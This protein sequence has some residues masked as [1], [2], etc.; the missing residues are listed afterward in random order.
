MT[1]PGKS[2]LWT[3]LFFV[4]SLSGFAQKTGILK[5]VVKDAETGETLPNVGISVVGT[6]LTAVTDFNGQYQ[7]PNVP[8]GDYSIKIQVL[9][10]GTQLINGLRIPGGKILVRNIQL[11]A[12]VDVLQTVTVL[13]QRAQVDL[14]SAKSERSIT[15][16]DIAQM[17]VR[18]VEEVVSLQAGVAKTNDG[19]QIRGARVYETEYLVDGISAQDPL[20]GTG[21]GVRVQS[22][23]IQSVKVTT[24]GAS[25]EF[26]GGSSGV[27]ST[28]IREGGDRL[29]V[30][31]RIT[32]DYLNP[33]NTR[34][35]T[36]FNTDQAELNISFPIPGTK[37]KVTLFNSA[38]A[39]IT[40]DYFPNVATQ[41]QSSL[42]PE[43]PTQWAPRQSNSW[44][45]TAKLGWQ[46]R[47][48]TK[49]TIT[50]QHSLNINQNSRTL[51]I[52]GFDAILAP[53]Y[54]YAR[55]KNLDNAATY[56]HHSNL[57]ALNL[58]HIINPKV[59]LTLS[60][61]RM[62][63]NLRADAN[64]RPFRSATVD[65]ILDE[66]NIASYPLD[67]FNPY[68][69][70]GIFYI[71]P[72][73]GLVNNGGITSTWHDH[74][75]QEYTLRGKINY[76]PGTV[77]Q[78]VTGWEHQWNEYQWVDVTT[79]WVGA[80]IQINDSL[81]TPSISIGSSNDIWKVNPQKGGLF[82]EDQINYKG[83]QASLGLRFN[84]WAPGTFADRAIADSTAPVIPAIRSDYMDKTLALGG[85]RWKAR[86]LPRINVSFP[87][88]PNNVLYF[89]YGHSM[90]LPHPRFLYAGLDPVYQDRS[91]LSFLGNP[92]LDPEVNV[93]YEVGYKAALNRDLGITVGAYNNNRF[94]YIVSRRVIVKDQTGRPV[95]KT[96]YINQDYAKIQGLELG[97]DYRFAR[98]FRLFGNGSFQVA[99]GK[100]NS[101]R[102]SA[103]QIEQNGEVS[104]TRENFLA[105]DRPW[106]T[107]WGLFFSADSTFRI[108]RLSLAGL[109]GYLQY[110]AS[111]GYRYT[112][113]EYTGVNDL[114][115]PQ[116]R[117]LI[118][119]YLSA[120]AQ[121]WHN[122][123]SK[124]S[125]TLA[126]GAF[127]RGI[128]LSVEVK[129]LFNRKN[130][131]IINPIT[132]R[133][134]AYGDDV[135]NEWRDPRP[136]F[137]GP[138]E[139]GLDPRDPSRYQAPRQ[140]FYGI[141]FK[142]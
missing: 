47:R 13:G 96:M 129:N 20:A 86:L 76:Y 125:Y 23:A 111:S 16:E 28:K 80:P 48:G 45:H 37:N 106:S 122:W 68:D 51:Q 95:T 53:G 90:R 71:R 82:V 115:R 75:A 21:F 142:L 8:A 4:L 35:S 6:Y 135:P 120:K 36:S 108:G 98:Y 113:Y 93:A 59:G 44:T 128:T 19:I 133:A 63:T 41:L 69:P 132:G 27:I 110:N 92:D 127:S 70:S 77:H 40:D 116:Y 74:Y 73:D 87:V 107:N 38:T 42:F 140:I 10:Y 55:S 56:T 126:R 24:G 26:G 65:A 22:S 94:D 58:T 85:L 83:I 32:R 52:V 105:W 34:P 46:L 54:Q 43:Y 57:S 109:S 25:A 84:Y 100:S 12:S 99:R 112:P 138:Q 97:V 134:Y 119:Q 88:T 49:L 102:E 39:D 81:S 136:E 61:G 64:G 137:N 29:E 139:S 9:G 5:G 123:D 30:S 3:L 67:V 79:P 11:S 62:F 50:N 2:R 15:G 104:L 33:N 101:A 89:N 18:S 14:E 130:A 72:G 17:N 78:V 121:S 114:G 141:T 7:I 31:G 124:W 1:L 60:V 103:L 131:Q 66:D 117:P 118:D 91:F